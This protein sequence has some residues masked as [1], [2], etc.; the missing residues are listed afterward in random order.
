MKLKKSAS[1]KVTFPGDM[2]CEDASS[3]SQQSVKLGYS[4]RI[5]NMIVRVGTLDGGWGYIYCK[6]IEAK[7]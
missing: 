1:R 6:G 3:L 4:W 7:G 2:S 5:S